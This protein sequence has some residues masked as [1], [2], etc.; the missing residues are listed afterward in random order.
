MIHPR[1]SRLLFSHTEEKKGG[2]FFFPGSRDGALSR[3]A[4]RRGDPMMTGS[5]VPSFHDSAPPPHCTGDNRIY[6]AISPA[7][8]RARR[9]VLRCCC[10]CFHPALIGP[11]PLSGTVANLS[12]WTS[13]LLASGGVRRMFISLIPDRARQGGRAPLHMPVE[14][15]TVARRL[16]QVSGGVSKCSGQSANRLSVC[17]VRWMRQAQVVCVLTLLIRTALHGQRTHPRLCNVTGRAT[18]PG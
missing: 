12:T 18:T 7:C 9:M 6:P 16:R 3:P 15:S 1:A 11:P 5:L 2:L 10:P 14:S 17:T 8:T 4:T 13:S